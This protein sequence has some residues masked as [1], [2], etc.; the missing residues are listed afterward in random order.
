MDGVWAQEPTELGE[1]ETRQTE[2]EDILGSRV[3]FH[4]SLHKKNVSAAPKRNLKTSH[5]KS[6]YT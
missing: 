1:E 2:M 5:Y 3:S 4:S 6:P